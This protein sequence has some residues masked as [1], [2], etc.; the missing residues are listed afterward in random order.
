[1]SDGALLLLALVASTAGMAAF[2]LAND[3]HWRQLLGT[4]PHSGTA[5][6]TCQLAGTALLG[7]AFLLCA[8]A[9]PLSMAILLWPMLLGIG[10]GLVATF[11]TLNAWKRRSR[12][13]P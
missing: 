4:R 8:L 13:E 9:D 3:G 12:S 2:A 5:R 6:R 11:F 10:A 7:V 1:M